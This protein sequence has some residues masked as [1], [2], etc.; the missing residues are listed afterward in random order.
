MLLGVPFKGLKLDGVR[1]INA[2]WLFALIAHVSGQ[3]QVNKDGTIITID[4]PYIT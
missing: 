4:A 3:A 2:N 1:Y